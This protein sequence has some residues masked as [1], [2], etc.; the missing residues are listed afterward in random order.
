MTRGPDKDTPPTTRFYGAVVRVTDINRCRTFYA[1]VLGL[2]DPVVDSKF[3]VEFVPC[4]GRMVVALEK[5]DAQETSGGD[6]GTAV[7]LQ[8]SDLDAFI[9]RLREHGGAV[10]AATTLVSGRKAVRFRDPERNPLL[11]VQALS[12]DG[13]DR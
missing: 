11:A 2:G 7:C 5:V 12:D 6:Q 4:A 8:V 10:E 1:Q 9:D 13:R 3:W